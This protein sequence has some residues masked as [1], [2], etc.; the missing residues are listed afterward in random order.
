MLPL[1][2]A[3]ENFMSTSV[4]SKTGATTAPK[5]C[6]GW[7]ETLNNEAAHSTR[8]LQNLRNNAKDTQASS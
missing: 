3:N 6:S 7:L 5:T 8:H 4:K 2:T 1:S